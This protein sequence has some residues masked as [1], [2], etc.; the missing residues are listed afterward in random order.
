M[1]ASPLP[2]GASGLA[3]LAAIDLSETV[4]SAQFLGSLN[5]ALPQGVEVTEAWSVPPARGLF[6]GDMVSTWSVRVAADGGEIWPEQWMDAIAEVNASDDMPVQRPSGQVANVKSRL[7]ELSLEEASGMEAVLKMVVLKKDDIGAKPMDVVRALEKGIGTLRVL[8][9]ERR[10]LETQ[11][12][13]SER[14]GGSALNSSAGDVSRASDAK[15]R[16]KGGETVWR[17]R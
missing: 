5:S 14:G 3:E 7:L 2:V 17:K 10:A 9:L 8:S 15:S 4:E 1:F 16:A 12:V 11:N 13:H 6:A